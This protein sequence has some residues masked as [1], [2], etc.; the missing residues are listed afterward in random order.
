[1]SRKNLDRRLPK[2]AS[3]SGGPAP[4]ARARRS[5]TDDVFACKAGKR[6]DDAGPCSRH[7]LE[8]V[9]LPTAS[10]RPSPRNARTHPARQLNQLA[11]SFVENGGM[12]S[13][14]IVDERREI[15]AGHGR[16]LA[17]KKLGMATVPVIVLGGLSDI[18]KRKLRVADNKI[19]TSSGW[20]NDKLIL[21]LEEF[22]TLP[23]FDPAA[24][25]FDA[26]EIDLIFSN[27]E[28]R[29]G[30]PADV[31]PE[32]EARRVSVRGDLWLLGEHRLLCGDA[33]NE[34]DFQ[35]L[36]GSTAA[37]LV[38]TDPPFDLKVAGLVGRGKTKHAEFAMASGEMG[39]G[40]F[41]AFLETTLGNI[42]RYSN[43]GAVQFICM[44]WRHIDILM[45]VGRKVYGDDNMLN[46]VVWAKSNGGQGSF[47]RSQHE[48]IAVFRNGD[49]P[50][51]NNIELGRHGRNRTNVWQYPGVNAFG[52]N[53]MDELKSH[54]TAKNVSM[55][56]DAIKDCSKRG[57][58]VL[59]C[60]GG[61]GTTLVAAERTGRWARLIEYEPRYVDVTIR[62]WQKDTGRDAVH[63]ETGLTF[64]EMS[65][66]AEKEG[67]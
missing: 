61:S 8:I 36:M 23:D 53:R 48:L 54:P 17:A 64:D 56:V 13:P 66:A 45:A 21:E 10:L 9:Y 35:R 3:E 24:I 55:I 16:L 14:I 49:G 37:A 38:F 18:Q 6:D 51:L 44:D 32:I 58:I 20:D 28:V 11:R 26:P 39:R 34:E 47:Y 31:A 19:A 52:K 65:D 7:R 22:I 43:D 67:R 57:D 15:I 30:D 62:R 41:E 59:D 5:S 4:K 33:R 60:F 12:V 2:Q 27:H 29:V 25:G 42:A 40:K 50:H 1:M 46:L 63:A